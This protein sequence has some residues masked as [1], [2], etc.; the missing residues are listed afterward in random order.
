MKKRKKKKPFYFCKDGITYH[1]EEQPEYNYY[2]GGWG[3]D[4]KTVFTDYDLLSQTQFL[5]AFG[6]A[7]Y[8]EYERKAAKKCLPEPLLEELYNLVGEDYYH[9]Y[10][11]FG[12]LSYVTLEHE[13]TTVIRYEENKAKKS[14][15]MHTP[16]L[17]LVV[18]DD[19]M[20]LFG[21]EDE[22]G[23]VEDKDTGETVAVWFNNGHTFPPI[24]MSDEQR[25]KN[26]E[27]ILEEINEIAA[28]FQK[29]GYDIKNAR[30]VENMYKL[31]TED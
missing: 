3:P 31:L 9:R 10:L 4:N 21:P 30:D 12:Y 13:D 19:Y 28:V 26:Q 23:W 11:Y 7:V 5:T 27:D 8:S 29:H 14:V 25:K 6:E 20:H 2:D 24:F 18:P 22:E 15:T 1:Y 16:H 17:T